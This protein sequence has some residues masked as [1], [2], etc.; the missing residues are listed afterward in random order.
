MSFA[1]GDTSVVVLLSCSFDHRIKSHAPAVV[2]RLKVAVCLIPH[3]VIASLTTKQTNAAHHGHACFAFKF[4][5]AL[6]SS[7]RFPRLLFR[8]DSLTPISSIALVTMAAC[9]GFILRM[10]VR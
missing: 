9:N 10:L 2:G 8:G 7:T 6:Y 4:V 5:A 1:F 3:F